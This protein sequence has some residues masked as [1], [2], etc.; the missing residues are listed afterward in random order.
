MTDRRNGLPEVREDSIKAIESIIGEIPHRQ[1]TGGAEQDRRT[2]S[3][4]DERQDR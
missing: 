2:G 3:R 1:P 4:C